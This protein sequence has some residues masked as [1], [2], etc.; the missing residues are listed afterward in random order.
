MRRTIVLAALLALALAAGG[1]SA[2]TTSPSA[3]DSPAA[4]DAVQPDRYTVETVDPDDDLTAAEVE[5]A[6]ELAWANDTVRAAVDADEPVKFEVWAPL[7]DNDHTSVQIEQN[8]RLLVIADVD[9]DAGDVVGV[10]EP[11]VLTAD[12]AVRIETDDAVEST[13]EGRFTVEVAE[14]YPADEPTRIEADAQRTIAIDSGSITLV[15]GSAGQ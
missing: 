1:V 13:D 12:E 6:R 8:D 7:N 5:Q 2:A 11:T 3:G 14:P 4:T 10:E 9:L 15:D